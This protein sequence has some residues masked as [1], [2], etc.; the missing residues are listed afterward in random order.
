MV[1]FTPTF[2]AM[3]TPAISEPAPLVFPSRQAHRAATPTHNPAWEILAGALLLVVWT[4]LWSFFLAGVV[5]PGVALQRAG[6][7]RAEVSAGG[8]DP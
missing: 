6:E 5:E 2:L 4:L 3:N 7:S 1:H 8:M